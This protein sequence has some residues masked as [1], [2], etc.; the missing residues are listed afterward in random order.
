MT[1]NNKLNAL[2]WER[3]GFYRVEV[4]DS[5]LEV[6]HEAVYISYGGVGGGVLRD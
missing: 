4:V 1:P 3:G 6:A 5:A 2:N